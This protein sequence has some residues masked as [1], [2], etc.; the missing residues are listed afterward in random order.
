[1]YIPK[2]WSIYRYFIVDPFIP[3]PPCPALPETKNRRCGAPVALHS[4]AIA[5]DVCGNFPWE[6]PFNRNISWDFVGR[7]RE[8][9]GI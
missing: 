7:S 3:K 2:L 4:P 8:H 9:H 5:R 6:S 1:M